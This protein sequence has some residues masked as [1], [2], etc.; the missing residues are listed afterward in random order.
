MGVALCVDLDGTLVKS[1]TLLDTVLVVAR[2]K[3]MELVHIPGWI[4]QGRA[5]F[6]RHLTALV[7]LDVEYLPYNQPL[8]EYL[9]QQ[10]GEG[11]EIY[12][13]TAADRELAERIA[14]F[15]EFLRAC[16]RRMVLRIWRVEISWRRFARSLG[17]IS[18]TSEMHDRMWS[19]WRHACRRW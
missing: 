14:A 7:T 6:K 4:A 17:R 10:Y 13:A 11:R 18:A 19:C 15:W 9:R 1:D 12:L 16:W 8:L 2:Q 5:A 3:P